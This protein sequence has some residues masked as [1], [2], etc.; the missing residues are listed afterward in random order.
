MFVECLGRGRCMWWPIR[1]LLEIGDYLHSTLLGGNLRLLPISN[2]NSPPPKNHHNVNRLSEHK[3][4]ITEGSDIKLVKGHAWVSFKGEGHS[5]IGFIC[6]KVT[7]SENEE[8]SLGR[9]NANCRLEIARTSSSSSS[10]S[11]SS[12]WLLSSRYESS[13]LILYKELSSPIFQ[14]LWVSQSVSQASVIPVQISTL[15]NI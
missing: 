14:S 9:E 15:C 6:R 5:N 2:P 7:Q 3:K 12:L 13:S 10:I 1:P 8:E 11:S 4:R